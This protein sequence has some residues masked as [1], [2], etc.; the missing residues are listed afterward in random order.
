MLRK[1]LAAVIGGVVLAFSGTLAAQDAEV[2]TVTQTQIQRI[3]GEVVDVRSNLL[4]LRADDGSGRSSYRI[5]RGA[6]ISVAGV[7][8]KLQDLQPG[9]KIRIYYRET[10]TGRVIVLSPPEEVE[11]VTVI[12]EP[13]VVVEEEEVVVM[14]PSTASALPLLGLLG[15]GFVSLGGGVAAWRRRRG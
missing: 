4:T 11:V 1:T 6:S 3:S 13:V 8:T 9:Q 2:V 14:L 5:P 15:L 12:E 7:P 10:E